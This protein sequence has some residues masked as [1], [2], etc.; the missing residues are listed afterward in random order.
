MWSQEPVGY[1]KYALWGISHWGRKHQQFYGFTVNRESARDVYLKRR[2]IAVTKLQIVEWHDYK[3][4]DWKMV[5]RDDEKLYK[6]KE[7]DLKRLHIQ[8]IE[9]MLLLLE[10]EVSF[11][12]ETI[13]DA[14]KLL[15]QCRLACS[16]LVRFGPMSRLAS[17]LGRLLL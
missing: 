12:A 3:H 1:D 17:G 15:Q 14:E 11:V 10:L 7:G 6:F 2:I 8:D 9:D 13:P 16:L 5:R 4:L